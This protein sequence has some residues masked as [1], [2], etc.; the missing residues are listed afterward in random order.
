VVDLDWLTRP[1]N[2]FEPDQVKMCRQ[3]FRNLLGA[4]AAVT[5]AWR[6]MATAA[7][8]LWSA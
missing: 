1:H 5:E 6:L 4:S 8:S 2:I 3:A 7:E